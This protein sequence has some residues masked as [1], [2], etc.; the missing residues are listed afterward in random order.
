METC[1]KL[2]R[3]LGLRWSEDGKFDFKVKPYGACRTADVGV[4]DREFIRIGGEDVRHHIDASVLR[5]ERDRLSDAE[6]KIIWELT[7]AAAASFNYTELGS[8]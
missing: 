1:D 8:Y 2:Y 3:S 6:R 5:G 7:G 4:H